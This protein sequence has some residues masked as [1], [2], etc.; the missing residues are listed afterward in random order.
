M[1]L[2]LTVEL[3]TAGPITRMTVFSIA[4]FT[5]LILFQIFFIL[6]RYLVRKIDYTHEKIFAIQIEHLEL[7]KELSD[8]NF[9]LMKDFSRIIDPGQDT[10]EEDTGR[11]DS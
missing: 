6:I 2:A 3:Y 4:F 11:E 5:A 7:T 10:R 9:K 1:L 8:V